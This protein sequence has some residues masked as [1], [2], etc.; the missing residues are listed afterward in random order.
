M[1]AQ[2]PPLPA[3]VTWCR[4]CGGAYRG[5]RVGAG[6]HDLVAVCECRA[7]VLGCWRELLAVH[8]RAMQAPRRP[9]GGGP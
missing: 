8:D 5:R 9:S 1:T 4:D 2:G 7:P 3:G 6:R